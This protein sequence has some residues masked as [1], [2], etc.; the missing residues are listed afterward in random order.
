M[1]DDED[2]ELELSPDFA[3]SGRSRSNAMIS[4]RLIELLTSL[5][6]MA[7]LTADEPLDVAES[8]R[9][10]LPMDANR[11]DA[12]DTAADSEEESA[13]DP[14]IPAEEVVGG[15]EPVVEVALPSVEDCCL[16]FRYSVMESFRFGVI[17]ALAGPG[18]LVAEDASVPGETATSAG[19]SRGSELAVL[20]NIFGYAPTGGIPPVGVVPVGVMLP[21]TMDVAAVLPRVDSDSVVPRRS[22]DLTLPTPPPTN[23]D[24]SEPSV[25]KLVGR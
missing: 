9:L 21:P 15:D 12:D 18:P 25:E 5:L 1:L 19:L 16:R 24:V 14:P 4:S 10:L 7:L 11:A 2:E 20:V 17:G 23:G 13:A 3:S 8:S 6:L 22:D